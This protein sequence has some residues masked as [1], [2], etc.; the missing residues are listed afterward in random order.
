MLAEL[1]VEFLHSGIFISFS[2]PRDPSTVELG[3]ATLTMQVFE[4]R[5]DKANDIQA[6]LYQ[7]V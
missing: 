2:P 4:Q 7:S 6:V 5:A 1:L 3:P